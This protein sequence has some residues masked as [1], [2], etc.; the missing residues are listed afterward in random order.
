MLPDNGHVCWLEKGQNAR[1][2]NKGGP[3]AHVCASCVIAHCE[4]IWQGLLSANVGQAR[5]GPSGT[6]NGLPCQQ[7]CAEGPTCDVTSSELTTVLQNEVLQNELQTSD[8]LSPQRPPHRCFPVM[9]RRHSTEYG[10]VIGPHAR[11]LARRRKRALERAREANGHWPCSSPRLAMTG[12]TTPAKTAPIRGASQKS[13]NCWTAQ[14][15]T[16]K[17][18]PVLRAGLTERLVTG[19]PIR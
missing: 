3:L 19:M 10:V 4:P 18:G 9:E 14:P 15:P 5:A 11:P 12:Y 6:A 2:A 7:I 13:H 8:S 17:A 16:N 1:M